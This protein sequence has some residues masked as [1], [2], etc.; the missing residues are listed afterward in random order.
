M[1]ER[2]AKTSGTGCCLRLAGLVANNQL[3]QVLPLLAGPALV[4]V[5]KE[6]P[7]PQGEG[8]QE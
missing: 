6:A 5:R 8:C 2:K 4:T 3:L 7:S 1:V